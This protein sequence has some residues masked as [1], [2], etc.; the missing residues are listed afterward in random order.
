VAHP[1]GDSEAWL[2][3]HP[4]FR[5]QLEPEM[6][7]WAE[8]HFSG[9]D[10]AGGRQLHLCAY[11]Y[12]APRLRLLRERGFEKQSYGWITRR[13]RLGRWA[14]PPVPEI[15]QGYCLRTTHPDGSDDFQAIADLLNAAF[16][17][18]GFH[19]AEEVCN[20]IQHSPSFTHNLNLLAQAPDGSLGAH[21]GLTIDWANRF[22]IFEPVCTHPDHRRKRLAQTLMLEGLRRL[23]ALGVEQVEVSTGDA[24]AA[25][26]LYDSLGFTEYYKAYYWLKK[27]G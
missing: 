15:A 11:E 10:G 26:A 13:M 5:A 27:T 17:R 7:A 23:Q 21:A 18:P 14:T 25:N 12:D 16:N 6:L 4:A 1:E 19:Q 24:D 3:I 20:F 9:P 8:E 2:E 22:A